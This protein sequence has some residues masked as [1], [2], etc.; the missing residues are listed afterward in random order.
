MTLV[1]HHPSDTFS[2]H[3]R[4]HCRVAGTRTRRVRARTESSCQPRWLLQLRLADIKRNQRRGE[5]RGWCH[6][7]RLIRLRE[8]RRC[9]SVNPIHRRRERKQLSLMRA[10]PRRH[11]ISISFQGYRATGDLIPQPPAVPEYILRALEYIKNNPP[12]SR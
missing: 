10:L 7:P 1:K 9:A 11:L 4:L 6:S 5:R 2:I 12:P 8:Q 3:F